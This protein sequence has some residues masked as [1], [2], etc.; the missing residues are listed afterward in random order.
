MVIKYIFLLLMFP[1]FLF[2]GEFTAAISHN[3][4]NLGESL[5]LTLTL[6]NGTAKGVPSIDSLRNSFLVGS[7]HQSS[8]TVITNGKVTLSTTWKYSLLPQH[9]GE[10]S[11]PSLSIDTSNGPLSSQPIKI[12]VAKGGSSSSSNS[13]NAQG[14]HLTTDVSN[15]KPYKNEPLI[16]T[17]R[18]ISKQELVNIKMQ[19]INLEDGMIEPNGEPKIYEKIVDG[20]PV[21]VVEFSYLITPLKAGSLKI[22]SVFIQGA[23]PIKRKSRRGF[24]DD[25][26]D[27][28]SIM[29][30][31]DHLQPFALATEEVVLDI[32]PPPPNMTP[33]LPAKS[34]KM[35][36]VW[37]EPQQLKVGDPFT[38]S[39]T[40]AADGIKS[41]QLPSLSD[42]QKSDLF[43]IYV[44]KPEMG[45]DVHGDKIKSYRKEQY[46]IIPQQPG[47]LTLPEISI[48]WWNV[49]KKEKVYATV[50]ARTLQVLP[51]AANK[52]QSSGEQQQEIAQTHSKPQGE[53]KD[54]SHILYALIAGLAILLA[55]AIVWGVSLKKKLLRL[56]KEL[57]N[58]VPIEQEPRPIKKKS[59]IKNKN[60]KLPD[61]N[62]T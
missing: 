17:V 8:N 11:I 62:P 15:A 42:L 1:L 39:L 54:F 48:A 47:T 4:V 18:L 24:F 19:K 22:P 37:N 43:K 35:E 26:F 41:N 56:S 31:F 16:Y 44:D 33:W 21:E 27:P 7:Q 13:G 6:K 49:D 28:F 58:I 45:D 10:I 23:I 55:A 50:P 46:T 30:G 2:S 38:R 36:E 3:Q 29:Q 57:K 9:E 52:Q 34:V 25:D 53:A 40:I 51:A 14:V 32:Q 20:I 5:T 12:Q 60:E 61:L 59:P